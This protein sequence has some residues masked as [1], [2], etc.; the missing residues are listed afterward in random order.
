[1]ILGILTIIVSWLCVYQWSLTW[2]IVLTIFGS[3]S[4]LDSTYNFVESD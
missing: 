1:M 3:L 4:I 2:A